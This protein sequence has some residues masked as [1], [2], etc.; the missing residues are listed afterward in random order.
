MLS[1]TSWD[2]KRWDGFSELKNYVRDFL[3]RT[4]V[5]AILYAD[6]GGIGLVDA[7]VVVKLHKCA[8]AN[9]LRQPPRVHTDKPSVV[10]ATFS[11]GEHLRKHS[12]CLASPHSEVKE[13][14]LL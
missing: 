2:N 7:L 14:T 4:L 8:P 9:T 12:T 11:K 3:R 13:V 5:S 10:V 6:D 1:N